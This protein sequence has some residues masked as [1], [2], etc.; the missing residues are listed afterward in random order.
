[1]QSGTR[2]YAQAWERLRS[3]RRA[4][5]PLRRHQPRRLP[6][7]CYARPR[8]RSRPTPSTTNWSMIASMRLMLAG[9]FGY[10]DMYI[11]HGSFDSYLEARRAW[12]R[13]TASPPSSARGSVLV[14]AARRRFDTDGRCI[15]RRGLRLPEP[16][17]PG[18]DRVQHGR[19]RRA[20][21]RSSSYRRRWGCVTAWT[22]RRMEIGPRVDPHSGDQTAGI[23]R[24]ASGQLGTRQASGPVGRDRR[25]P[26]DPR[27]SVG[28]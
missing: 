17:R 19:A 10:F 11:D 20:R 23:D 2:A 27:N 7:S 21:S 25:H 24:L 12:P 4:E 22:T 9:E 26:S 6:S 14:L 15:G 18:T 5:K 8:P 16:G 13:S 28:R 1:M 3:G